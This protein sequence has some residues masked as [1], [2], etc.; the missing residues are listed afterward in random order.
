MDYNFKTIL[1]QFLFVIFLA[2][3]LFYG[4]VPYEWVCKYHTEIGVIK[5]KCNIAHW[6]ILLLS[7]GFF[8][9]SIM[10]FKNFDMNEIF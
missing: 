10:A 2:F 9:M 4:F 6:M 3:A 1:F 5:G 7:I 8:I